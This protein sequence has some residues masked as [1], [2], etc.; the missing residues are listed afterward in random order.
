MNYT[1]YG[2][3]QR[4]DGRF[5]VIKLFV[6]GSRKTQSYPRY[7]ME[8]HLGRELTEEEQVDHI[9]NDKLDNRLENLQLLTL[10][11]NVHKSKKPP[12]KE[13]HTC[14]Q[15]GKQFLALSRYVRHNQGTYKRAG[16]FCSKSCA[17]KHS[18]GVCRN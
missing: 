6:D 5:H 15:C 2:P 4:K 18:M 11:Q 8:Q 10:Q 16:P 9:N 12:E 3:Y 7:L 1:L 14:P 13:Q 17:G